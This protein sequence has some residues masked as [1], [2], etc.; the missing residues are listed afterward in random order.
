M[1]LATAKKKW[2]LGMMLLAKLDWLEDTALMSQYRER[3]WAKVNRLDALIKELDP[4]PIE[5]PAPKPKDRER[6]LVEV[7]HYLKKL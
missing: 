7:T 1:K 6:F 5:V 4:D 3:L 2:R